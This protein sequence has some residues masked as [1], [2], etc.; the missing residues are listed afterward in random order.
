MLAA[1]IAAEARAKT[2]YDRLFS[3]TGDPGV[4]EALSFLMIHGVTPKV[5]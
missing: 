2:T 5:F 3:V 1:L 4:R